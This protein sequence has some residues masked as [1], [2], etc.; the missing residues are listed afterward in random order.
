MASMKLMLVNAI[1]NKSMPLKSV[2]ERIES[3]FIRGELNAD[4][5]EELIEM[6]HQH[7]A[8][9]AELTDWKAMYEALTVRMNALTARIEAL[10]QIEKP[11]A[12]EDIDGEEAGRY[13]E[14]IAWDGVN[15]GYQKGDIVAHCG[16]IWQSAMDGL[17]VWEPGAPGVDERYWICIDEMSSNE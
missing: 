3:L 12:E 13:A 16:R 9:E 8:P 15:G 6:M 14:W 5:H 17:N 4:E 7:A 1:K 11:D 10:E 2:Y